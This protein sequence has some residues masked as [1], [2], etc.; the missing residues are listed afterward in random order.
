M[1]DY[2]QPPGRNYDAEIGRFISA[3]PMPETATGMGT[4][5]YA[6]DNPIMMND[7]SGNTA[8]PVGS[9][10]ALIWA[11]KLNSFDFKWFP[12][13]VGGTADAL[14]FT[15]PDNSW[16]GYDMG[17][18]GA[19]SNGVNI[20]DAGTSAI[21]ASTALAIAPVALAAL[22]TTDNP[23]SGMDAF[24]FADGHIE[25]DPTNSPRSYFN[26]QNQNGSWNFGAAQQ[27]GNKFFKNGTIGTIEPQ[28]LS[29]C[30]AKSMEYIAHEKF[31][32]PYQDADG[33]NKNGY[34]IKVNAY[35]ANTFGGNPWITGIASGNVSALVNYFFH[36]G[37]FSTF[38]NAID[39]GYP[40]M[41]VLDG[42][43]H[44]VVVV[45]YNSTNLIY[46]DPVSG[47]L[48]YDGTP[49]S[50]NTNTQSNGYAIPVTG[51]YNR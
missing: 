32:I 51:I 12:N 10:S 36:T 27:G 7:P 2:Y 1:P 29:E 26:T 25:V 35:A 41:T 23:N 4:Y 3:D 30:V 49:A 46:M 19:A 34:E 47:Q 44:N 11:Q 31:R 48:R 37:T 16:N 9:Q 40:I 18:P 38:Q 20:Y 45:G 43:A 39:S 21:D 50:F 5:H 33:S 6:G 8:A 42:I 14:D 17:G 22:N 15:A 24:V 13:I 28:G